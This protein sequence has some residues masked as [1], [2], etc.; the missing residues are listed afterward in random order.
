MKIS[1]FIVLFINKEMG[2]EPEEEDVLAETL[3]LINRCI[4]IFAYTK[5]S[6]YEFSCRVEHPLVTLYV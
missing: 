1:T 3:N 2:I 6:S 5:W 4:R